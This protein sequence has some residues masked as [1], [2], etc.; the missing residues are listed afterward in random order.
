[1]AWE[2]KIMRTVRVRN[3]H[4]LGTLARLMTAISGLGASIGTMELVNETAQ[5]VVRDITVYAEDAEHM[6]KVI[7]AMR[8]NEGTRVL[9]VRDEVLELHQKGKIAIRSRFPIDSIATLRRVYTPGVAEVC[10]K[11]A[12]DPA[13]ARLYT[14]ISH[15]V[16][17]VTD[18]TAVLGL[19]DIGPLA[20]MPVMEGKAML[21]ETLVGLSGMPI[22]LNTK[23]TDEIVQ[24]VA[25]ISPTFA[26]IQLED[27]SA[28]R[29]FDVEERLQALLDIPV[30]HDDQHG[31]AVVSTAALMT[32]AKRVNV[33]IHKVKIG[34]VGLGAAGNAIG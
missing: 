28:P 9:A 22:L 6:D 1:M 32:A 12:D 17:I 13:L 10:L 33:D 27:I 15:M 5:S 7:E 34:Q 26:A 24:A 16:A 8:A 14:S 3:E 21:M 30:M 18:G 31:T 2:R 29:C 11:I 4:K 20:S 23:D 19:G 25:A